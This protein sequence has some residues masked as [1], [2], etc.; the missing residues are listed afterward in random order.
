MSDSF[1]NFSQT[2]LWHELHDRLSALS[3]VAITHFADAPVV[4]SWLDFTFKGHHFS[5]SAESGEFAFFV[6][7]KDC[8]ECVRAEIIAHLQPFFSSQ[9]DCGG[10]NDIALRRA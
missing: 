6:E 4:G 10:G 5:I 9:T 3:G 1:C 7:G 8:P 2:R